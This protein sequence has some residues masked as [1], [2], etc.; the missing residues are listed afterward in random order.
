MEAFLRGACG[1]VARQGR[2]LSDAHMT[3]LSDIVGAV[4]AKV[5]VAAPVMRA[6]FNQELE[7]L[8]AAPI[9][10]NQWV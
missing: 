2:V 10:S 1:G 4:I 3:V 6:I 8:G 7:R 9:K 5:P